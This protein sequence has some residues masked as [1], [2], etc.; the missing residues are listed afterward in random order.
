MKHV[1][2]GPD[3]A[4]LGYVELDGHADAPP[5][6]Y[7]HGL[8]S[9]S[10]IYFAASAADPV[11]AGRRV[12]MIDLLGFGMSDRPRSFTYTLADQ[13]DAVARGLDR[14]GVSGA[15]MIGHSMGGG[16]ATLLADRRPD[17]V[18]RLVLAEPSLHPFLP[19][20]FVEPYTEEAFVEVGFARLLAQVG[21]TWAA[22]VRL[23]DPV[24]MYRSEHALGSDMPVLDD[25]LLALAMPRAIVEGDR[26]G[27]LHDYPDLRAAGIP[28]YVVADA[29]HTMMLDNPAGFAGAVAQALPVNAP[30][31]R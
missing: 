10:P 21:S 12:L 25:V 28:V 26:S 15:D 14:L 27:W 30:D 5:L 8:G 6:V 9:C 24:A 31:L 18:G 7:L 16:V 4:R 19:R 23:A 13:A 20:P 29:G 11:L 1:E 3:G 22:T 2:V 17:L